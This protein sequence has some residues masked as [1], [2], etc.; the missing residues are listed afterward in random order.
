MSCYYCSTAIYERET[1]H[2]SAAERGAYALLVNM[3]FL[4]CEG[5]PNDIE[6]LQFAC[7]CYDDHEFTAV[8]KVLREFFVQFKDG[9]WH[10]KSKGFSATPPKD[11]NNE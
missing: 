4:T 9:L 3:Y 8:E 11:Y 5:L 10:P 2:L 7:R 1:A 6:R